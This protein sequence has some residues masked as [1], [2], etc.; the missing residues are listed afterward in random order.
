MMNS[1]VESCFRPSAWKFWYRNNHKILVGYCWW[2]TV[3]C[4]FC[5]NI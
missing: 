3:C 5:Y 4:N 2:N 1:I